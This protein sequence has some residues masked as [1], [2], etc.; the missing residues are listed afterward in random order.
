MRTCSRATGGGCWLSFIFSGSIIA[1]P[2]IVENQ[3]L[4]S[5]LFQ[6]DGCPPPLH[7]RVIMPSAVPYTTGD[8]DLTLLLAKSSS[9]FLLTRKIPLLELSQRF[10]CPSSRMR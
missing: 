10:A 1:T 4:P 3:S 6:P 2:L 9:S 5:L 7:S 8:S